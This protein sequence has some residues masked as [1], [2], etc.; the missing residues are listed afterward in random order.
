MKYLDARRLTGPNVIWNKSGAILDIA[1]TTEEADR[2]IP[3]CENEIR[4]MLEAVGWG[5]ESIRHRRL[6]G[7]ISI[8]F[9][10]PIDALYAASAINEWVWAGCD[11]E[12]NDAEAPD[13]KEKVREIK[14]AIAEEVNPPLLELQLAAAENGV[15]FLWDDDD[16]S[17]GNG[18]G[19]ETW[20]FRELPNPAELNWSRYHDV[21]TGIV[22]GTNGK[23]TT[24]R[25][26]KQLLQSGGRTVGLSCTDWV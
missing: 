25:I 6:S 11:A 9:S 15:S 19:S 3:F 18:S 4:R 22:T 14:D 24:V 17:I 10:A 12:F 23:T 8:A 2:L 13:F 5:N 21:P 16:V 20:P 1:C 26:A 7:G